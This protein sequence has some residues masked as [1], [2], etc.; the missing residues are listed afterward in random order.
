MLQFRSHDY[1]FGR[2]RGTRSGNTFS[3][4]SETAQRALLILDTGDFMVFEGLHVE[5]DPL[6]G[7]SIDRGKAAKPP[8]P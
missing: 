6:D 2:R 4:S 7:D 1:L 5:A 8:D 3:R